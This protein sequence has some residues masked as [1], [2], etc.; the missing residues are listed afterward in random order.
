MRDFGCC[1]ILSTLK[2]AHA[3]LGDWKTIVSYLH[4]VFINKACAFNC[5]RSLKCFKPHLKMKNSSLHTL[6]LVVC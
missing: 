3:G 1:K 4:F 5:Q 2:Q 6:S